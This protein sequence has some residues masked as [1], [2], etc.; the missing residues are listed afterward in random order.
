MSELV[1]A[2]TADRNVAFS[3][4]KDIPIQTKAMCQAMFTEHPLSGAFIEDSF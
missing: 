4:F 2:V 1:A 3:F